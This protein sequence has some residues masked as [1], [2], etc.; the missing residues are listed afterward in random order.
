MT[1]PDSV[2]NPTVVPVASSSS[3]EMDE[4]LRIICKSDYKVIEQLSQTQSNISILSLLLL[5]SETHRNALMKL[6][7]SVFVPQNITL[8]QVEGFMA[9]VSTDNGLG[10]TYIVL[11]HEGRN[12]NKIIIRPYIFQW[13]AN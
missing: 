10:F 2:P 7:T 8:N 11:P 3:Q 13:N 5:C 12:H 1:V 9:S 4:L 6:L